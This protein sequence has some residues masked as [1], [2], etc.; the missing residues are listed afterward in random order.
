MEEPMNRFDQLLA[1]GG[2][3]EYDTDGVRVSTFEVG[4]DDLEN[5]RLAMQPGNRGC[6]PGTYRRLD[7]DGRLW[8]SDTSAE[9]RDHYSP[10]IQM[11][12]T[13]GPVLIHGLGMGLVTAAA[14]RVGR[15]VEVVEIDQRVIDC[16]GG[17]LSTLAAHHGVQLTIHHDDAYT[18]K[19]PVGQE[20]AVVWHDI[21]ADLCEDNLAEMATLHRRFGR[22]CQWQG[23]WGK[24]LLQVERDRRKRAGGWW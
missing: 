5:L 24:T 7:V 16:M 6:Q 20:W 23:S 3:D 13:D 15:D 1:Y 2:P 22:R 8:M 11:E 9:L 21:W 18:R 19:W 12:Q 14:I 17:W 10:V 4:R